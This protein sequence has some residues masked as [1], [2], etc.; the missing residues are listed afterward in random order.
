MYTQWYSA[1]L[2][3]L[4]SLVKDSVTAVTAW[5]KSIITPDRYTVSYCLNF[6]NMQFQKYECYSTT[7]SF[8]PI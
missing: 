8:V 1:K 7:S 2:M 5:I 4:L 3:G 6:K